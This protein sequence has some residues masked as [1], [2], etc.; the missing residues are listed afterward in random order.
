MYNFYEHLKL[1][2]YLCLYRDLVKFYY[3]V[4]GVVTAA[5]ESVYIAD[6]YVYKNAREES[7]TKFRF[8]KSPFLVEDSNGDFNLINNWENIE[9]FG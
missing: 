2:L 3:T 1:E 8:S 5:A 7:I 6:K 4:D 9:T